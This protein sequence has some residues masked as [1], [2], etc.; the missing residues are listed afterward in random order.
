M[1]QSETYHKRNDSEYLDAA[2]RRVF[3]D[4]HVK[5]AVEAMMS[6]ASL[7]EPLIA[8]V[9]QTPQD[10]RFHAEG[11]FVHAHIK[12]IL[13]ALYA[14]SQEKLHLLDIEE[15]R[16]L[17]GYAG[18][19]E[20][21]EE[22]IKEQVE[23]FEVFALLHDV[24]KWNAVTFTAPKG[25]EGERLGFHAPLTYELSTDMRTR[26]ELRRAYTELFHEFALSHPKE[27][28]QQIQ[29][30]FYEAYE[31]DVHYFHH[32]TMIFTP[33]YQQLLDRF[34]IAHG[35]SS[36][37]RLL[38]EDLISHHMLFGEDFE[39]VNPSRIKRYLYLAD[40]HGHDA[41]HYLNC[42]E[43]CLFLDMVCGSVSLE[44]EMPH[45]RISLFE[46]VL[47]SEHDY[48]PERRLQKEQQRE[49][50]KNRERNR[51]FQ[52]VGLDGLALLDLLKME[53]GPKF[54]HMLKQIHGAILGEG[55]MPTFSPLIQKELEKRT[56]AFYQQIFKHGI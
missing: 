46:H 20:E 55:E 16:R 1:W 56:G 7:A 29:K 3:R 24:A 28:A 19:L 21:L 52:A 49:E 15:F 4:E 33:V 25:S 17:K 53:P 5:N 41:E 14:I 9:F 30:Q 27:T 43:I 45:H 32:D 38:L 34:V 51:V 6:G 10:V 13:T 12:S 8:D 26:V 18:K 44:N 11:P 22:L 40:K 47:K 48:A 54:G 50:A 36:R 37:D 23:L 39:Q 35:L 42:A 2:L 31:I